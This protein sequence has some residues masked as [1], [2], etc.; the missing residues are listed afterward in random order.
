MPNTNRAWEFLQPAPDVTRTLKKIFEGQGPAADATIDDLLEQARRGAVSFDG[1]C[2]ARYRDQTVA[3]V[4]PQP[5]PGRTGLL[6]ISAGGASAAED[7]LSKLLR[8]AID[9]FAS[10]QVRLA[11]ALFSDV[12]PELELILDRCGFHFLATLFYLGCDRDEFPDTAPDVPLQFEAYSAAN[13]DRFARVVEETY[14]ETLDCAELRDVRS[15]EEVL[16]GYRGIGTSS[17]D[18]WFLV[19]HDD[20]DVGCLLL[21][22]HDFQDAFELVYMGIVPRFRGRGWGRHVARYAQWVAGLTG[23]SRVLLAVDSVNDPAVAMYAAV[24]F[25]RWDKRR[26]LCKVFH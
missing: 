12:D 26:V 7:G 15:I 21:A 17:S 3:A 22:K 11:Y 5:L 13:H 6:W 1:L 10:R 24:G 2:E 23:V 8:M 25:E 14:S 16:Q 4:F 18:H 19:R 20:A 9:F